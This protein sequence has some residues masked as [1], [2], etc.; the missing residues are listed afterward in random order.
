MLCPL[1]EKKEEDVLAQN[2]K[3]LQQDEGRRDIKGSKT[4]YW[5]EEKGG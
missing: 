4:D 5:E 1:S 2:K 3:D